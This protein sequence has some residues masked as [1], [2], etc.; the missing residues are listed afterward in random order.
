METKRLSSSYEGETPRGENPD[1]CYFN[2]ASYGAVTKRRCLGRELEEL[3]LG[4]GSCE[5]VLEGRNRCKTV[6]T[7]S[8]GG[9]LS[10]NAPGLIS[11]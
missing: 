7:R 6:S 8:I 3:L 11:R 4:W 2:G 10:P 5:A 1:L 9:V